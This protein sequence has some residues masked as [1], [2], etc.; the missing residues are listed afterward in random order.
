MLTWPF[1]KRLPVK[2]LGLDLTQM[3]TGLSRDTSRV[4]A[5]G[6]VPTFRQALPKLSAELDRA[7]RYRRPLAIMIMT[8]DRLASAGASAMT[9]NGN[10]HGNGDGNGAS[11]LRL[12]ACLPYGSAL[13]P[14][15]IASV[16][17]EIVRE[18]DIVT[19]AA[20][21]ECC[22]VMMPEGGKI[23]GRHALGRVGGLCVGRLAV[24]LRAGI[25]A[26]PEDGWTLEELIL[27]A[28]QFEEQSKRGQNHN[29]GST[30]P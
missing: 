9:G 5:A 11:G 4:L 20:T 25:A 29:D 1:L 17:R 23:E 13:V 21:M 24:P 16:V 30:A 22:V 26:F 6:G 7:R 15:F 3:D 18:A 2:K 8:E 28:E 10:G 14:A 27:R 12:A 19:Y